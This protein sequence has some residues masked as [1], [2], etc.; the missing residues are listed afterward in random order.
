MTV[1]AAWIA[2]VLIT[3]VA[4]FQLALALG[5]PLGAYAW[6]GGHRGVL[7]PRLQLGSALSA[8]LLLGFAIMVL[9]RAGVVYPAWS[10]AMTWPVWILFMFMVLNTVANSRS[11]S[12]EE[13]RTMT[14]LTAA[15]AL[16]VG[17]VAW[18]LG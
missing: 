9:I 6:G 2:A 14:P 7:P 13:R 16:L 11:P 3:G 12:P 15:L 4:V 17:Y 10:A 5:A 8:P 18:S 1:L